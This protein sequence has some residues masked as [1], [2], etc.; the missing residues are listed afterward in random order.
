MAM[1]VLCGGH[2]RLGAASPA[3]AAPGTHRPHSTTMKPGAA[4]FVATQ[5]ERLEG[6]AQSSDKWPFMTQ[7]S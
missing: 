3:H 6:E 4:P 7:V 1:L 5:R 2:R